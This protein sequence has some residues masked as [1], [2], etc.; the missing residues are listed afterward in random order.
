MLSEC[1]SGAFSYGKWDLKSNPTEKKVN[2]VKQSIF[3][4]VVSVLDTG[5][6]I[7]GQLLAV[8]NGTPPLQLRT[9]ANAAWTSLNLHLL[10]HF[11]YRDVSTET[12]TTTCKPH[13]ACRHVYL[14]YL[15]IAYMS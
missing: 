5:D 11:S 2:N 13:V 15:L 7:G 8:T 3:L 10:W 14:A 6:Q 1:F 9:S 12:N 4:W